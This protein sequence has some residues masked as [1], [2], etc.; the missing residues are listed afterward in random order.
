MQLKILSSR[1]VYG[2]VVSSY[3][4]NNIFLGLYIAKDSF[5]ITIN[6]CLTLQ[7]PG[8]FKTLFKFRL[9]IFARSERQQHLE[10]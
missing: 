2:F 3:F 8:F 5:R 10:D 9:A 6:L 1:R 4:L 7:E